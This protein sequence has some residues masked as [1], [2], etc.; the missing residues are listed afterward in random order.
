MLNLA[1]S[2]YNKCIN[3]SLANQQ[4]LSILLEVK[5][6]HSLGSD[7]IHPKFTHFYFGINRWLTREIRYLITVWVSFI[8]SVETMN[9]KKMTIS[10]VLMLLVSACSSAQKNQE[11]EDYLATNIRSDGSKE[12]NY[13]V[14][15]SNS[16]NPNK[17][18][19]GKNVSG[20][21]RVSGGSSSNTRGGVGI[22]VGGSGNHQR[23]NKGGGKRRQVNAAQDERMSEQLEKELLASGF[24]REGWMEQE[25]HYQPPNASIRGECNEAATDKDRQNFPNS[26]DT[27]DSS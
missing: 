25:R 10:A 19:G 2:L 9:A 18:A 14:T 8:N 7:P 12:F 27:S 11:F 21:A 4:L 13:T 17:G 22:T 23:G 15:M 3:S 24:C 16:Q 20:G 6:C 26:E 1:I 5:Q